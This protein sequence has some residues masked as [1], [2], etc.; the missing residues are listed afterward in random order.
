[1]TKTAPLCAEE[2]KKFRL[3]HAYILEDRSPL[4]MAVVEG[5]RRPM[6]LVAVQT[7]NID[8]QQH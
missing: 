3:K 2:G 7:I 8:Q 6:R 5:S 1:M 4:S